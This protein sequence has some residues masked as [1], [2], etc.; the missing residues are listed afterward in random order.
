LGR[1]SS[2]AADKEGKWGLWELPVGQWSRKKKP[3]VQ[4]ATP[5][6]RRLKGGIRKGIG[7]N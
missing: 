6:K 7:P 2:G 3:W 1:N 5:A 4:V